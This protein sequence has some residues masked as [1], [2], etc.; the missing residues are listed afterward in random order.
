MQKKVKGKCPIV[1]SNRGHEGKS[2]EY[3]VRFKDCRIYMY[4]NVK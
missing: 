2:H 1:Q 3:N 4:Y